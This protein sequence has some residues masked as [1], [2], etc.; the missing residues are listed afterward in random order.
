M[1]LRQEYR[2]SYYYADS[3]RGHTYAKL[4]DLALQYE[5]DSFEICLRHDIDFK[6]DGTYSYSKDTYQLLIDLSEFL[7]LKKETNNWA[8]DTIISREKVAT[9][10]KY[11][12]NLNTISIILKYSSQLNDWFGP[13]LPED[14]TFFQK[15]KIWL[16]T[17][18]HESMS[19][20]FLTETEH[21]SIKNLGV[22][23]L[24][25]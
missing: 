21:S 5:C 14:I 8:T 2:R 13:K 3:I 16:A 23:F 18:G 17:I 12:F 22:L 11:S 24:N 19:W 20:W 15:E 4:L 9:L 6:G 10:Y 7:I 1:V 25:E